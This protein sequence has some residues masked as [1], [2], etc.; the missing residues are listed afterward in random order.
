MASCDEVTSIEIYSFTTTA[1]QRLLLQAV[2]SAY[3]VNAKTATTLYTC[4]ITRAV[5][6]YDLS[7][8]LLISRTSN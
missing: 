7:H 8:Q 5:S 4:V 1:V 3:T 6:R 2:I